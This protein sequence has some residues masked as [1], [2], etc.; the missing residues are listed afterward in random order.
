[1]KLSQAFIDISREY[2]NVGQETK[3][4]LDELQSTYDSAIDSNTFYQQRRNSLVA[5]K[6]FA[7]LLLAGLLVFHEYWEDFV[8]T[9]CDWDILP[10]LIELTMI[11]IVFFLVYEVYALFRYFYSRSIDR[12]QKQ[13]DKIKTEIEQRMKQMSETSFYAQIV[14]KI[15]KGEDITVEKPNAMGEKITSLSKEIWASTRTSMSIEKCCNFMIAIGLY[16]LGFMVFY[17]HEN[18]W[19]KFS[20]DAIFWL[21]ALGFYYTFAI[22]LM[23]I[24]AGKY[25]GK[26]MRPIGVLLVLGY[27]AF[28][29]LVPCQNYDLP[30]IPLEE[31]PEEIREYFTVGNLMIVFQVLGMLIS[32]LFANYLGMKEKWEGESFELVMMYG[33]AKTKSRGSVVCRCV[34]MMVFFALS[35]KICEFPLDKDVEELLPIMWWITIP[36]VK[37]F[38]STLYQYF[39]RAKCIGMSITFTGLLVSYY[40]TQVGTLELQQLIVLGIAFCGYWG[41][42]LVVYLLN[43]F[44]P[45]FFIINP[46]I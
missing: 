46:L 23:I 31:L 35:C 27:G 25:M 13:I 10:Y 38:G 30:V 8:A 45:I 43:L 36:L 3:E 2:N 5:K 34:L 18:E 15:E 6:I 29:W 21:S 12:Y 26:L 33:S 41:V 7:V 44:T 32:V 11:T 19:Q 16:L 4:I 22:D 42:C 24:K 37:P 40:M 9:L 1:M 39:G 14:K 20:E 17:Q 28:L